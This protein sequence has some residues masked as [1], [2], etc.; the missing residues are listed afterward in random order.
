MNLLKISEYISAGDLVTISTK[1]DPNYTY[2][3][4]L[5]ELTESEVI[6]ETRIAKSGDLG[7]NDVKVEEQLVIFDKDDVSYIVRVNHRTVIV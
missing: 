3:G 4:K 1:S 7:T 6:M 5:V 2:S